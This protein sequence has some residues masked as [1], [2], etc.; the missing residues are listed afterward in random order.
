MGKWRTTLEQFRQALRIH[1]GVFSL[2]AA[3]LAV[4]LSRVPIPTKRLRLRVF[5]AIYGKKYS[6]LDETES[7]CPLWAYSSFNALFTRGLRPESRPIPRSPDQILAPCDGTI[8][9]IGMV[10]HE[11][12]V[13]VKGVEYTIASLLAGTGTE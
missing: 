6:P 2:C 13:T 1:G 5:R 12:I 8:Q 3:A 11:K 9:D 4:R 10:E 7:E